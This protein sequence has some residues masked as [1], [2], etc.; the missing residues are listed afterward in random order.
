MNLVRREEASRHSTLQVLKP[1]SGSAA[2]MKE[3]GPRG[4]FLLLLILSGVASLS[5]VH[6]SIV[7]TLDQPRRLRLTAV[8]DVSMA[9]TSTS[10]LNGVIIS[11]RL[12]MTISLWRWLSMIIPDKRVTIV[13]FASLDVTSGLLQGQVALTGGFYCFITGWATWYALW[14][15][16]IA[17]ANGLLMKLSYISR[18]NISGN[19]TMSVFTCIGHLP[20]IL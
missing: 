18:T 14:N 9:K 20:L 1:L 4:C 7:L 6:V 8:W 5:G 13:P 15:V 2:R 12:Y 19:N 17:L 3:E 10:L 11:S 16:D